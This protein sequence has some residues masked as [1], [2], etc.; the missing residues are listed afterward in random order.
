MEFFFLSIKCCVNE[1]DGGIGTL[2][3]KLCILISDVRNIYLM[4]YLME[5]L[6]LMEIGY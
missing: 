4:I 3:K 5:N 1:F 6:H 2:G